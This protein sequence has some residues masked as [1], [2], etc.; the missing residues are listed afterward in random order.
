MIQALQ[1]ADRALDVQHAGAP[2]TKPTPTPPKPNS[3]KP[4]KPKQAGLIK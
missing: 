4:I 2:S 3:P 1:K